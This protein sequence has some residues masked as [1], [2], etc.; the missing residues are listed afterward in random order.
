[1]EDQVVATAAQEHSETGRGL[2]LA[3][4]QEARKVLERLQVNT[5]YVTLRYHP[6][7]WCPLVYAPISRQMIDKWLEVV[8]CL[9]IRIFANV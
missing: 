6:L 2:D 8:R 5:E 4:I 7:P 9:R 1:M 3:I